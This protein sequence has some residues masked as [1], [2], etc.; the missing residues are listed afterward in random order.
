MTNDPR[1]DDDRPAYEAHEA[2]EAEMLTLA[3]QAAEEVARAVCLPVAHEAADK[4]G[5]R[6]KGTEQKAN[7][8]GGTIDVRPHPGLDYSPVEAAV[9]NAAKTHDAISAALKDAGISPADPRAHFVRD[10]VRRRQRSAAHPAASLPGD[11]AVAVA[12]L[13]HLAALMQGRAEAFAKDK[14]K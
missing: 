13:P 9:A 4:D 10:V 14:A 2:F 3:D 7:H 11:V 5:K 6:A 1:H 8:G 12:A